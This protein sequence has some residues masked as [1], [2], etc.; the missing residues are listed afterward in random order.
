VEFHH[1]P[2][3]AK[4]PFASLLYLAEQCTGSDEDLP[5]AARMEHAL[6]TIGVTL[7]QIHQVSAQSPH[8][9]STRRTS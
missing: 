6:K 3:H 8:Q 1:E 9:N 4:S 5:S 2:E 7:G